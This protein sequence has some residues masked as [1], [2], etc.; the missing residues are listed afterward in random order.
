M[1]AGIAPDGGPP[2]GTGGRPLTLPLGT[3]RGKL[4]DLGTPGLVI[5][6]PFCCGRKVLYGAPI[7]EG[8]D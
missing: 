4:G 7:C 3:C 6:T 2:G 5:G 1:A 8:G